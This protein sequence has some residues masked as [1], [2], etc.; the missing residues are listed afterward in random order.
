M[1]IATP[2]CG[3]GLAAL[4]LRRGDDVGD[5]SVATDVP[6]ALLEL[7]RAEVADETDLDQQRQT[8]V[9]DVRRRRRVVI[10]VLIMEVAALANIVIGLI[11]LIGHLAGLGLL[12]SVIG[13]ALLLAVY[14]VARCA[15]LR[16]LA[17]ATALGTRPGVRV[18]IEGPVTNDLCGRSIHMSQVWVSTDGGRDRCR[19]CSRGR[20]HM[21]PRHSARPRSSHR[22]G[23]VTMHEVPPDGGAPRRHGR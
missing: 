20:A 23:R 19:Q 21:E 16:D 17:L 5:V 13:P 7:L 4:M 9:D 1:T 6:V 14:V 12:A 8:T 18:V 22:E 11:A 15:T 3:S 2:A 10:A